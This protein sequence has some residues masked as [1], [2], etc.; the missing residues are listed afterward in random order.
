MKE[1]K[2][3]RTLTLE[4]LQLLFGVVDPPLVSVDEEIALEAPRLVGVESGSH[5]DRVAVVFASYDGR[6]T[7]RVDLTA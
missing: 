1:G 4:E 7:S 2:E 6:Q 3:P 5:F